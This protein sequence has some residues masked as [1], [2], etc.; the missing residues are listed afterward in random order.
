M[1]PKVFRREDPF[2]LQPQINRF[3][4]HVDALNAFRARTANKRGQPMDFLSHQLVANLVLHHKKR[5]DREFRVVLEIVLP[6]MSGIFPSIQGSGAQ[7]F[8]RK[9]LSPVK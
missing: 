7:F 6:S 2:K 4:L 1:Q 5:W 9:R 8:F 3:V